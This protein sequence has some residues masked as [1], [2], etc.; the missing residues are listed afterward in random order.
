MRGEEVPYDY[1]RRLP[2]L[3]LDPGRQYVLLADTEFLLTSP[4]DVAKARRLLSRDP[5]LR[6]VY[7]SPDA[8]I[9]Q[10]LTQSAAGTPSATA[11]AG[12]NPAASRLP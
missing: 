2:A 7:A 9:Y 6:G 1:L 10:V 5:R 3:A 12:R 4:E 11:L 8:V